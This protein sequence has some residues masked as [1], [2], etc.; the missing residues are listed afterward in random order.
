MAE[1]HKWARGSNQY[2]KKQAPV[3]AEPSV[4]LTPPRDLARL[5]LCGF[6]WDS[7]SIDFSRI[8]Q[9][10]ADKAR[11]RFRASMPDLIWNAAA[12][13]GN[14][15]T[16]PEVRTL[17]DGVTVG[18][19]SLEDAEQ[20]LALSEGYSMADEL[21]R[22]GQFALAK[23]TS[24]RLHG[25][26]ARHEAI[27][28]GHFRGEGAVAGGGHVRLSHGGL[29][30]PSEPGAGG[31]NLIEEMDAL[32]EYLG[33][34]EDPRERALAYFAGATRRQFY[35]DGNKRSARLMMTGELLSHGYDAVDVPFARKLEFN[36]ALDTL[37]DTADGTPLMAF[38]ASCAKE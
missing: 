32:L 38:L 24:D 6:T 30:S 23:A 31:V 11:A 35:F 33:T 25:L 20:I 37:F 12:L 14:N 27:E 1:Q 10:G 3:A 36:I 2:V 15:F 18:G 13:E 17:L 34:V 9:V 29:Y 7:A 22:D 5:E 26:V 28:S 8:R 21:V 16:L 19:K 4:R